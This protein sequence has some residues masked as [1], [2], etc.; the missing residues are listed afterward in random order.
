M[1]WLTDPLALLRRSSAPRVQVPKTFTRH[2]PY[3]GVGAAR[4]A[5]L[6]RRGWS[7]SVT[8]KPA[9]PDPVTMPATLDDL[10]VRR[11][12]T[13]WMGFSAAVGFAALLLL[14]VSG[15]T[16]PLFH[17]PAV[18]VVLYALSLCSHDAIHDAAHDRPMVNHFIGW[19]STAGFG[20]PYT[21]YRAGHLRHHDAPG[22]ATDAE[23]RFGSSMLTLPIRLLFANFWY[24]SLCRDLPRRDHALLIASSALAMVGVV[25]FPWEFGVGWLLPAQLTAAVFAWM[26][27]YLPHGPHRGQI[28]A[29]TSWV[30]EL[31][32][33]HH[34]WPAYPW[35]QY[36][37]L[38]EARRA[39]H[40]RRPSPQATA[41]Q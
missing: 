23:T 11:G 32:D 7:A 35:Y 36:P 28:G 17:V 27:V 10:D 38:V 19:I 15:A 37:A 41:A 22:A 20:M 24:A 2:L 3:S 30:V 25:L 26:H 21:V 39:R 4:R 5:P 34:A 40:Q 29:F 18:F 31:H 1:R 16:S 13:A 14:F 9:T 8:S 33:G 12:P 6:P